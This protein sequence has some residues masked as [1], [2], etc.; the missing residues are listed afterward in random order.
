MALAWPSHGRLH[1]DRLLPA[2]QL[3][4]VRAPTELPEGDRWVVQRGLVAR[5]CEPLQ[6]DRGRGWGGIVG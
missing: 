2:H 1:A 4:R 3:P 6:A 5:A